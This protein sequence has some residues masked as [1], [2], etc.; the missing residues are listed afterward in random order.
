MLKGNNLKD[1][2]IFIC[3]RGSDLACS[4]FL[5]QEY[6]NLVKPHSYP[7]RAPSKSL[8][9][10]EATVSRRGLSLRLSRAPYNKHI[11]L[12]T[13]KHLETATDLCVHNPLPPPR[14]VVPPVQE[15]VRSHQSAGSVG[16]RCTTGKPYRRHL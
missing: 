13:R 5:C 15:A 6:K 16:I 10:A 7:R 12:Q 1:L 3:V 2:N 14:T 4:A 9:T 8:L 11:Q